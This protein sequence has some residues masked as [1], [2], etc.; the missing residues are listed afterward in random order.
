MKKIFKDKQDREALNN[1]V[2]VSAWGFIMVISSFLF[3][4]A[5]RWIDVNFNTEP[6]FMIGMLL[7][8]ISLCVFRMYKEAAERTRRIQRRDSTA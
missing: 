7:L 6:S 8:G 4:Y 3:M 2:M 1:V 5:G